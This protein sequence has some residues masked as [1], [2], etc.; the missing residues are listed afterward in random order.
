LED[1]GISNGRD[2]DLAAKAS[3]LLHEDPV[4]RG[5]QVVTAAYQLLKL[6]AVF[7]KVEVKIEMLDRVRQRIAS[8][9]CTNFALP[10]VSEPSRGEYPLDLLF[11]K[12]KPR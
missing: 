3:G 11:A 8:H 4:S 5:R 6:P 1:E 10:R 7:S 2:H 9:L 12:N